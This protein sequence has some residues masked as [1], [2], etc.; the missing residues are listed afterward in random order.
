VSDLPSGGP[1]HIAARASVS[2]WRSLALRLSQPAGARVLAGVALLLLGAAAGAAAGQR[3]ATQAAHRT[4]ACSALRMAAALGYL[5]V[6]QQRRVRNALVT[7]INPDA[8]L[9]AGFRPS[10]PEACGAGGD[11]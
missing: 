9:F 3:I 8:D 5:D 7:A 2:D 11:R 4:G 1:Q 10:A 6:E